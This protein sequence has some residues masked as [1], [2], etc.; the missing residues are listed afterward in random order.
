MA[1]YAIGDVQGCF[2][3]FERLLRRVDFSPTHDHLWL[4]GDMVNRGP[5]SLEMLRWLV[6]HDSNVTAVLGNHDLYL[7]ARYAGVL[8]A[9]RRDTLDPILEAYDCEELISWVRHRPILHRSDSMVMVHAGLLPQWTIEE[10]EARAHDI[11]V[12]LQ[13]HQFARLLGDVRRQN[14]ELS[15][16]QRR[17]QHDM[18]VFTRIRMLRRTGEPEYMYNDS[19][20]SAPTGLRPWYSAPHRRGDTTMI[21]GHWAALGLRIQ[22]GLIA[23]DSG[24]VWG[25]TLSAYRLEDGH[26]FQ[27][28]FADDVPADPQRA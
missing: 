17:L 9:R 13:S 22:A 24:C 20:E 4:A 8:G 6:A 1:T 21:F 27:E 14:E 11:E 25:N 5:R 3:T 2:C 16:Q 7:L 15:E 12:A 26:V 18:A 10:A 23:L 19:P 28:P